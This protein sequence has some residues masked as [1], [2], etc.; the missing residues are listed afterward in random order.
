MRVASAPSTR[1]HDPADPLSM[2]RPDARL[3]RVEAGERFRLKKIGRGFGRN[4]SPRKR[5]DPPRTFA[6]GM[7]K[8]LQ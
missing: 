4:S 7:E 5:K 8:E 1:D 3:A 6:S 2:E